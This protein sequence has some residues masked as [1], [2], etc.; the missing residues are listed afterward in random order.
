MTP[1]STDPLPLPAPV[2]RGRVTLYVSPDLP[3]PV[4]EDD[5]ARLPQ[6]TTELPGCESRLPGTATS[7]LWSP[8]WYGGSGLFVRQ[9]AHGGLLGPLWGTRFL[10]ARRMLHEFRVA[11]I[12][13]GCGV[14]TPRPVALC[15]VRAGGPLVR[16]YYVSEALSD[17]VDLL[18]LFEAI[19]PDAEIDVGAR[20]RLLVSI[21]H[22]LAAMHDAGILHADLN[23]RNLMVRGGLDDPQ[24]FVVDLDKAELTDSPTL[25]QRM[26]NLA[27]LDRSVMKWA[28][29]R[30]HVEGMDR[31][32]LLRSYLGRYPQWRD[33]WGLIGRRYE[34]RHLRHYMSRQPD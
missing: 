8:P 30:R 10:G 22:A 4:D 18:Q 28:A 6:I 2:Q 3:G 15:V 9:Y 23:V 5:L 1:T 11:G 19:P 34:S 13:H 20:R 7:W 26:S 17:A 12:A 27:R 16:G 31:L 24:V 29:S 21:A 14:P 25:R 32:R 33:D